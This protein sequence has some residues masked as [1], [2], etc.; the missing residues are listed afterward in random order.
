[1][2]GTLPNWRSSW[3]QHGAPALG[4]LVSAGRRQ[5]VNKHVSKQFVRWSQMVVSSPEE[6][7]ERGRDAR[8]GGG[9]ATFWGRSRQ[10]P[11]EVLSEPCGWAETRACTGLWQEQVRRGQG[12]AGG[13]ACG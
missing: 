3:E 10:R 1:M 9:V 5:T 6:N 8:D 13:A 4:K 12:T 2:S 7:T 11:K